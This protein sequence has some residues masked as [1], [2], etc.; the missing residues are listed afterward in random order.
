MHALFC[1]KIW[2]FEG[3]GFYWSLLFVVATTANEGDGDVEVGDS[4]G[5]SGG[6][7]ELDI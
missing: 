7:E 3:R 5:R 1:F 4:G 6:I 2:M